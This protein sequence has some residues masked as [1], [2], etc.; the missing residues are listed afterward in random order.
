MAATGIV[1]VCVCVCHCGLVGVCSGEDSVPNRNKGHLSD[2]GLVRKVV[3]IC[4][5]TARGR[6][7]VDV[8]QMMWDT[9]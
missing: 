4:V 5:S 2:A 6:R 8:D 1:S 3:R 7:R 9:R